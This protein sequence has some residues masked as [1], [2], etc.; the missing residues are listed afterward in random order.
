MSKTQARV[1]G[2]TSAL[3]RTQAKLFFN[4]TWHSV[5]LEYFLKY[6]SMKELVL[7]IYIITT[8]S[9]EEILIQN[10]YQM[11]FLDICLLRKN[12]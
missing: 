2:R 7:E 4:K 6:K 12:C 11:R 3:M 1:V 8:S 5:I 10:E 9:T